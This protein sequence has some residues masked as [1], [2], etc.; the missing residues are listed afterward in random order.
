MYRNPPLISLGRRIA[1][2][3][4]LGFSLFVLGALLQLSLNELGIRGATAYSDDLIVGA[5][6]GVLV[7][8]YEQRRYASTLE[9]IK[10]IA[11]MNHHVRNALQAITFS[12]YAEH[13]KQI[14][15]IESAAHR[16]QWALD[17]ILPG[18]IQPQ[19]AFVRNPSSRVS[20][21]K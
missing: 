20:S 19:E 6:A 18:Q 1:L 5:L 11:A 14:E 4:L 17:E 2:S 10:V 3:F 16:I 13:T 7:F 21:E 9:R 8:A 12:P 15:L